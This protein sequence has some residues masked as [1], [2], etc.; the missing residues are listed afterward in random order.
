[1]PR[2]FWLFII[3][4]AVILLSSLSVSAGEKIDW[5]SIN[6]NLDGAISLGN[7]KECADC[8]EDYIRSFGKTRHARAYKAGFGKIGAAA[9][10]ICHGPSSRHVTADDMDKRI[11]SVISFSQ[12]KPQQKNKICLQC[13]EKGS[14]MHW[15]GSTHEMANVTCDNCH[16]SMAKKSGRKSFIYEDSKKVCFQCHKDKRARIVRSAHMPLRE[17]KMSCA[18]C[19][20][21]H[22]SLAPNLLKEASVNETC[23][24]CH[25]EKRGPLIWE[26]GPVREDCSN[27]HDSHGTN[28]MS[29]LKLKVPYLCQTCHSNTFH[30]S[31]LFDANSLAGGAGTEQRDLL[32]KSCLNCHSLIHGS[33]HP[34]GARFTR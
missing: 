2:I 5:A 29:M 33:N 22:G 13:H 1:M 27:C 10:E 34:S 23:Y 18:S 11:S 16:Y 26:H 25:Q 7:S 12:I 6:P 30:P 32:G 15:R 21:A 8:H 24:T 20:D 14:S 17:G 31:S 19:H 3:V 9:C 4:V 28:H